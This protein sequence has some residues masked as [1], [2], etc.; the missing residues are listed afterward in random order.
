[1]RFSLAKVY[2]SFFKFKKI[3]TEDMVSEVRF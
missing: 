1:M 3:K 2:Y